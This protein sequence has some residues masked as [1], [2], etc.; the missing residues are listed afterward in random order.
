[1]IQ[2][3][4]VSQCQ[5]I[6]HM[7]PQKGPRITL[8]FTNLRRFLERKI[9][10]NLRNLWTMILNLL[11]VGSLPPAGRKQAARQGL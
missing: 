8:I 1:M 9:S 10:V 3:G 2:R 5:Q 6:K 11:T 4:E 7:G